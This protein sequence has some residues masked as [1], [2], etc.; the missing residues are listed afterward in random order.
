[1]AGDGNAEF[2]VRRARQHAE[3][4]DL[5]RAESTLRR[6]L[7]QQPRNAQL[8]YQLALLYRDFGELEKSAACFEKTLELEPSASTVYY[9]YARIRT[10]RADDPVIGQIRLQLEQ[11]GRHAMQR[12]ELLFA[13]GKIADDCGEYDRAFDCWREA[14]A[15]VR[16]TFGYDVR[17]DEARLAAIK[18]VFDAESI[19]QRQLDPGGEC[20]PVFVVGMPRSGSTLCEQILASHS[21]VHGKGELTLLPTLLGEHEKRSGVPYPDVL[22]GMDRDDLVRLRER[23]LEEAGCDPGI[24]CFTDKLPANFW[25]VGLIRMLFPAAK[26][27]NVR[28]DPRDTTLSCYKH[29]FGG[30]QKFAYDLGEIRRFSELYCELMDYWRQLLPGGIHDVQYED[31]VQ[32][33]QE[34]ITGMLGFCGLEWQPAC[35]D[36]HKTRR[37]VHSSSA[38]QVREPLHARSIR[39]SRNYERHLRDY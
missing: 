17:N 37:A 19:R 26:V 20:T 24:R 27:I 3:A 39:S 11:P 32:A 25:L 4:G 33:P 13:L 9:N 14:N 7:R 23:Y 29:L 28:R 1:L 30:T 10:F 8:N 38:A 15:L 21:D 35:L 12:A 2:L 6:A 16:S 22:A 36:F 31:L 18:R 5:G 34:T